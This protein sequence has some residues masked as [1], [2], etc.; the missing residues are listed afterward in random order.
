M[1]PSTQDWEIHDDII[2]PSIIPLDET[3]ESPQIRAKFYMY[4]SLHDA[5]GGIGLAYS[6]DPLGPWEKYHANPI[7]KCNK[8]EKRLAHVASPHVIWN[9]DAK[10]FYMYYHGLGE[11]PTQ[12][13][14]QT[15]GIASSEDG[16][17]WEKLPH[18]VID[19]NNPEA[20]DGSELSYARVTHLDSGYRMLYMARDRNRSAPR[21]G[22]AK[23]QDGIHWSKEPEP[24]LA[25]TLDTQAYIST[26]HIVRCDDKLILFYVDETSKAK[27]STIHGMISSDGGQSWQT[28]FKVLSPRGWHRWD[29]TRVHDPF[30][31]IWNGMIY[32]YYVGGPRRKS[33]GIGVAIL[34]TITD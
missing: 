19:S 31:L 17:N 22:L 18:P 9:S 28:P 13:A 23:S 10:R 5:P 33:N 1:R 15:T 16:I 6:D 8:S 4:Y 24:F 29:H 34:E 32:L 25:P 21:L 27:N 11:W 20:W 12:Q 26:G 30:A 3:I 2:F 14:F 7:L